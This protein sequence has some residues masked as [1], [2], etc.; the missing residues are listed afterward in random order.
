MTVDALGRESL[1]GE[2]G[3]GEA[4]T[5]KAAKKFKPA[6]LKGNRFAFYAPAYKGRGGVLGLATLASNH[7]FPAS[8]KWF[9]PSFPGQNGQAVRILG[10]PYTPPPAR[11]FEWT[12]GLVTVFGDGLAAP[13]QSAVV[14]ETNGTLTVLAN[15]NNVELQVAAATGLITGRFAHP[16]SNV[17]TALRGAVLQGSNS[18]AGYFPGG[19]RNGGFT[20][21]PAP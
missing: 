11:L 3:D 16:T 17:L 9:G 1:A 8:G 15:T 2:L 5:E 13:L 4:V 6:L 19:L 21:R 12:N 18:A 20:L 10:S 14:V 7:T